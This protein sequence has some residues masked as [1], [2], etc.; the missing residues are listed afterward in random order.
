MEG[1]TV[2]SAEILISVTRKNT[3]IPMLE[4]RKRNS[5]WQTKVKTIKEIEDWFDGVA[6]KM[7]GNRCR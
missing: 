3:S 1:G 2:L 7:G 4:Y 6:I 5:T